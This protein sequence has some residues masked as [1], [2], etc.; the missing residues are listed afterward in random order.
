M[1]D[2]VFFRFGWCIIW[3]INIVI[4]N[5]NLVSLCENIVYMKFGLTFTVI[6]PPVD[7]NDCF[8]FCSFLYG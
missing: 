3:F 7:G 1:L 8:L 5:N 2:I 6:V 4:N